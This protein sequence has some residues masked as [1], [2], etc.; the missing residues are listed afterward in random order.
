[1]RG[2][3]AYFVRTIHDSAVV[4]R[5]DLGLERLEAIVLVQDGTCAAVVVEHH[6]SPP[7]CAC[8]MWCVVCG[9]CVVG[10]VWCVVVV[11]D[12]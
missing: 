5:G 6:Q 9:W 8:S 1:M 12:G 3:S 11:G 10:S 7:L 2:H 4:P